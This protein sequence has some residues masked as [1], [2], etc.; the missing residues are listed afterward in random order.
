MFKNRHLFTYS[1]LFVKAG[2]SLR[3]LLYLMA[4]VLSAAG[5]ILAGIYVYYQNR[6]QELGFDNT[7]TRE[8][9]R[10]YVFVSS[11]FSQMMQDIFD[12]IYQACDSTG[13]Y[14]EWCGRGMQRKYT[15]AEA[16]DMAIAMGADGI[17]LY[18]DGSSALEESIAK[19]QD[20]GTPVVTILRDLSD[21]VRVSYVGVSN[22]QMG[23]Q[24]GGWLLSLMKKGTSRVCLLQDSGDSE[25]EIQL[26]FTQTVQAVR[27]GS[28]DDEKMELST[29]SVDST[30]DFDAEE[31]I[32]NILLGENRPDI[33]I[34]RNSV[35]TECAI[36]ALVDYNLVGK[37]QV[38]GYYVT[39]TILSA[40]RQDL[41]PVTMMIDTKALGEDCAQALDEYL[42][43]ERTSNYYNIRLDSITPVTMDR[44]AEADLPEDSGEEA[45]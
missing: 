25:N 43:M 24:Y 36:Q 12:D 39:D 22:Y 45:A 2:F 37:V 26:L 29:R 21:S 6:A 18:P 30:V 10:H 38:I 1:H 44:Y 17:I 9:G 3:R 11:D 27:N 42:D 16:V 28:S 31:V 41:I 8:Y 4:A 40:L 13:A 15:A 23:E 19:A 14:L 5:I 20:E 7:A 34:C 35:Q 32:R 33:L